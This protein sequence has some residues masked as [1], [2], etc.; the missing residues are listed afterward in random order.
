MERIRVSVYDERE[1]FF[2]M[3]EMDAGV[4]DPWMEALRQVRQAPRAFEWTQTHAE[5]DL[6][7]FHRGEMYDMEGRRIG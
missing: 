6:D 5:P 2:T 1:R 4:A 3:V 7:G